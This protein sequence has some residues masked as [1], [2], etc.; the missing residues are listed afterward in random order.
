ME[1][2]LGY[3][4]VQI[5]VPSVL[6]VMLSWVSFWLN[7]DSVPARISLGVLTVLTMTTQTSA[8]G[9][10]LPRVSY[11][12]AIDIWM[13]TCL[14]FVFSALIEFAV[15]NVLTRAY[16]RPSPFSPEAPSNETAGYC[17]G[18]TRDQRH[19]MRVSLGGVIL[20]FILLRIL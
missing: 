1:R 14:I 3:Y 13:S 9:A 5:Y 20:T 11:T 18:F 7:V 4:L 15:A 16:H 8:A 12:K 6:I 19:E 10:T 17:R 2:N